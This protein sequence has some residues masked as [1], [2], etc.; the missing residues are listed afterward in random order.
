VP[1]PGGKPQEASRRQAL[2]SGLVSLVL[3]VFVVLLAAGIIPSDP[4]TLH[5]PPWMVAVVGVLIGVTGVLL[6]LFAGGS[7]GESAGY[8][9][10]AAFALTSFAVVAGWVAFGPGERGFELPFGVGFL[11]ERV[12]EISG[13]AAFG[14]VAVIVGGASV[15]AWRDALRRLRAGSG[16]RVDR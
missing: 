7:S 14:L 9:G 4:G 5:G 11:G 10:L 3:G 12:G 6:L 8:V 2:W 13:R 15:A 1:P 16:S